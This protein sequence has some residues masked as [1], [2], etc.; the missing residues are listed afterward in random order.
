MLARRGV[1]RG[2]R[3][4]PVGSVPRSASCLSSPS[5]CRPRPSSGRVAARKSCERGE[6]A[7][8]DDV[9]WLARRQ[10]FDAPVKR[11]SGFSAR[12]PLPR[13]SRMRPSCRRCR[14]RRRSS[15]G[16]IA[17]MTIPGRPAPLPTSSRRA[18]SAARSSRRNGANDGEAVE[19]VL[20]HHR[21]RISDGGEV[22]RAVPALDQADIGDESIGLRVASAEVRA[23]RRRRPSNRR[24]LG[25]ATTAA[26]ARAIKRRRATDRPASSAVSLRRCFLTWTSS[27]DNAAGVTPGRRAA[28]A[29]LAGRCAARTWRASN[30]S[31]R[32]AA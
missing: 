29:R 11:P 1:P 5:R 15:E 27:S 22:V 26:A 6:G 14:R 30:D 7:A 18:L 12:A 19:K 17:A 24:Q 13:G 8:G 32:T 21:S 10:I 4:R 25:V 20:D 9:E 3:R 28:A 23:P 16:S 2:T 31:A